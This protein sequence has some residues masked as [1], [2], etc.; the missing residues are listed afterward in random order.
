MRAASWRAARRRRSTTTRAIPTRWH[1]CGRCRGSIG[2]A[3][4]CS[5]TSV[6]RPAARPHAPRRG[7]PRPARAAASRSRPALKARPALEAGRRHP[8]YLS[9]CLR[10]ATRSVPP[11]RERRHGSARQPVRPTLARGQ[12]VAHALP[13]LRGHH[14]APPDR[15]GEGRRR[16]RLQPQARRDPGPRRRKRLRQDHD[17]PL[18]PAARAPD[19]RRDPLRRRRHQ[20][21]CPRASSRRRCAGASR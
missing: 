20:H 16:R 7:L 6:E 19:C 15:R 12:G 1:C 4:R 14:A 2:R 9:A 13:D 5:S 21:A 8:G 10:R 11:G 17:R 3:R 18:H